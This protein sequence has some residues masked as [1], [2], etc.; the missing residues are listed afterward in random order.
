MKHTQHRFRAGLFGIVLFL[1]CSSG[2]DHDAT[3]SD[4]RDAGGSPPTSSGANDATTTDEPS[5]R[6]SFTP[7][8]GDGAVE[9]GVLADADGPLADASGTPRADAGASSDAAART[10]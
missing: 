3:P 10:D 6:D 8:Q 7:A 2:L 4:R 5:M 1:G 9:V